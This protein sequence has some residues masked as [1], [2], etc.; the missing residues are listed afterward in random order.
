[1]EYRAKFTAILRQRV[2]DEHSLDFSLLAGKNAATPTQA[3]ANGF[4][5]F[6]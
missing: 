6:K 3:L 1:L 2:E 4:V 5:Y